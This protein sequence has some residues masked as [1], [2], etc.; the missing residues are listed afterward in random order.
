[1]SAASRTVLPRTL[2]LFFLLL[3]HTYS[4]DQAAPVGSPHKAGHGI[5]PLK[6]C[7]VPLQWAVRELL[8]AF[9]S[10]SSLE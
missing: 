2:A 8:H 1:M 7:E 6:Y 3:R 4:S 9:F 5:P 10:S